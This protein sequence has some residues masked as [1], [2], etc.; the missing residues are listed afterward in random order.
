MRFTTHSPNGLFSKKLHAYAESKLIKPILRH[1]IDDSSVT[2]RCDAE[3]ENME[4][5]LRV[6]VLISG[7]DRHTISTSQEELNAAIDIAADKM[8]R[9]LRDISDRKR[10]QKLWRT[11]GHQNFSTAHLVW[12]KGWTGWRTDRKEP[13]SWQ[14]MIKL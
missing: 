7:E 11:G 10:T 3:K 8:E 5:N 1:K 4:V 6:S 13:H 12:M 9:L 2:I 14:E